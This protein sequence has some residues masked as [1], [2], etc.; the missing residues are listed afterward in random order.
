MATY[1]DYLTRETKWDLA[2]N[3]SSLVTNSKFLGYDVARKV[4]ATGDIRVSASSTFDDT[5]IKIV[6]IPKWSIF[7]NGD[8]VSFCTTSANNILT[9]NNYIDIEVVQGIPQ[10][11]S[12]TA[13]GAIYELI[14]LDLSDIE[15]TNYEIYRNGVLWAEVSDLNN[16]AATD[17]VY[18]LKNKPNLNGIE[19]QF[20]NDIFGKKLI[21]GDTILFKYVETLGIE[22]N[23]ISSGI[24][25]T[26]VSTIYDIDSDAIDIYCTNTS[27]LDGGQNEEDAETI[28]AN[29]IDT[30]QAGDKIV[31]K[32]DYEIALKAS[33]LVLN[34]VAWGAYEYNI[35]NDNDPWTF[36]SSQE[37]VVNVSAY[38]PA[39]EQLTTPQ[40]ATLSE[41]LNPD[42]PPEDILTFSDVDF[43]YMAF[44]IA[45]Y[46]SSEEYALSA[47]KAAIIAAIQNEYDLTN[48]DFYEHIYDTVW[49]N[50]ITDID[51]VA[52]HDSYIELIQYDT[53]DSAYNSAITLS[54][55]KI[56]ASTV[57]VYLYNTEGSG[58][59]ELIGTDDGEGEFTAETGYDLTGS[60]IDY[61]TGA[62]TLV[63]YSG[64]SE[65]YGDFSIK[66]YYR[67]IDENDNDNLIL[68]LINQIFKIEEITAVTASYLSTLGE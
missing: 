48:K 1:N 2:M 35:I 26:V 8:D 68:K 57:K 16:S 67:T 43:I 3:I 66:T 50:I 41:L 4:G 15:N 27:N 34:A 14:E 47:V 30:F 12:Y 10:E 11:S 38:T 25:D 42:K 22:G 36:L 33:S 19:I 23:I 7:S 31:S 52:Y 56:V 45:S 17:K 51:G 55:Y 18:T 61:E 44:N 64:L 21:V 58:S 28:R 60:I 53:F 6:V 9:T 65:A 63:V 39:G 13:V 46:V 24:V 29:G 40:K 62:L 5:P 20:G 37:N 49:K 59:Y 32:T 54:L